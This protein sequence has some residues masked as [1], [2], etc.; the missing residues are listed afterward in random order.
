MKNASKLLRKPAKQQAVFKLASLQ[1]A[2]L[3][4]FGFINMAH[5]APLLLSQAPAS[6]TNLPPVPNVIVSADDSG[7]MGA[8][9]DRVTGQETN[10][11]ANAAGICADIKKVSPISGME[12]LR[13]ALAVA[14]SP[15][16]L[17]DN[18]IRL[19]YQSMNGTCNTIDK[20]GCNNGMRY[21]S[22]TH[23]T[24][25]L[26][27]AAGLRHNGATPSHTMM[28]NARI[29]MGKSLDTNSAWASNPGTADLPYL[30]CRK[31]Y[32][33][34]M[35]DGGWN[36]GTRGGGNTDGTAKTFPE[37]VN[38]VSGYTPFTSVTRAF[39]DNF[40]AG[41]VTTLSDMAFNQ[42][43]TD[44]QPGLE[45]I[46]QPIIKESGD[47]TIGGVTIPQ[48]WNPKN[49]PAT[50]QHI[51]TY[52]IGFGGASSWPGDPIFGTNTYDGDFAN[53]INGSKVWQNPIPDA[54]DDRSYELWHMALN[55]RGKF[56]PTKSPGELVA[57]FNDIINE[58]LV[59]TSQPLTSITASSSVIRAGLQVFES[60]YNAK[61]W[62]GKLIAL[63]VNT[64]NNT[65][66]S[67]PDWSAEALLN[68]IPAA[69]ITNRVVISHNGAQGVPFRYASLPTLSQIAL[70]GGGLATTGTARVDYIRGDKS[71]EQTAGT[72]RKRDSRLG[73]IVNSDVWY[74]GKPIDTNNS[75]SYT[76]FKTNNQN[77]APMVYVGANDGM[78]HGFDA[79]TGV[80]KLAYVPNGLTSQLNP[81]TDPN[82]VHR[83]YVD[84]S[85]FTGDGQV[86]AS[87]GTYLV[88]TLGAGGK[89]YFVLDVTNPSFSE[90]GAASLVKMDMTGTLNADI[91][92][93]HAKPSLNNGVSTQISKLNTTSNNSFLVL[94]NGYNSTTERAALIVQAL[95]GTTPTIIPVETV[96][97]GANGLGAP[98][99]ID[100]NGDTKADVAYAG[101]L[102]GRMWKFNLANNTVAFGGQPLFTATTP[103]GAPQPITAAPTF[104]P[105]SKVGGIMISFATG[106]N[107]TDLDRL[108]NRTQ[109]VYSVLDNST[110]TE[111]P[112]TRLVTVNNGN[113]NLN[114]SNLVQQTVTST[115]V[116]TQTQFTTSAN[117]VT[118]IGTGKKYGW[119][120]DLPFK[121]RNLVN[122]SRSINNRFIIDAFEPGAGGT[123]SESCDPVG[124]GKY[125]EFVFNALNANN[126][127]YSPYVGGADGV[128]GLSSGSAARI[129][130]VGTGNGGDD[131]IKTL[132]TGVL[133]D[134]GSITSDTACNPATGLRSDGS[135]CGDN[136][137]TLIPRFGGWREIP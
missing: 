27:W 94:G 35:T 136:K 70:N 128:N 111:N 85:P 31:T 7:S 71:Q 63:P 25:F 135:N 75:V 50:W 4:T 17:P 112:T 12:S 117:P 119:M 84:G 18:K 118:Y 48:F 10:T 9:Y 22:G 76:S 92:F 41:T 52:T 83:Y 104:N 97:G 105:N 122:A 82:Y 66:S 123:S 110:Y 26:L 129:R 93:I 37:T 54:I 33:M 16:N 120:L 80:E 130:V 44:I 131:V 74:T 1:I 134:S 126:L 39:G 98:L 32:H 113:G 108:D 57:A 51:T 3:C 28:D 69:G 49:D 46:V 106:T 72:F 21:L 90:S 133:T 11:N 125:F 101:D 19:A 13:A 65:I 2:L 43:S 127:D 42:W 96:I 81:L 88:G 67:T 40:G 73:D 124:S 103:T 56:V 38:G 114:R 45:N 89:G 24:N 95:D 61:N 30:G 99:L 23:R 68:A 116:G 115:T 78:L 34:L 121:M 59:D 15:A 102:K 55:G 86:G 8:C 53:L 132:R 29:Y 5:A 87:W 79:A 36:G 20:I 77:R 14:F 58:I 60:G 109:T 137:A 6:N 107:L 91:G 100:V 47:T 64:S 62:T